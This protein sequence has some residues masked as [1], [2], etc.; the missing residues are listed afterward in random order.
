MN[1]VSTVSGE[2]DLMI[3]I[4]DQKWLRIEVGGKWI[5]ILMPSKMWKVNESAVVDNTGY[6]HRVNDVWK[7][8]AIT[9]IRSK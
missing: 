4:W 1:G 5:D 8:L 6:K 9:F 7:M 3:G 2:W